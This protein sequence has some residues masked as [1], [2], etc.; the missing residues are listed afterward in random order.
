MSDGEDG[1]LA[2]RECG[3]EPG[4]NSVAQGAV[5]A[6]EGFVEQQE[7]GAGARKGAGQIDAL[8]FAAGK[9]RGTAMPK[10]FELEEL[11]GLLA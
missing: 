8:L 1:E 4:K 2:G 10:G 3:T 11:A 5:H 7:A 9:L 6:G